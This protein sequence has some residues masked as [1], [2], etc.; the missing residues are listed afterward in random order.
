MAEY[1][2][3]ILRLNSGNPTTYDG[4][5]VAEYDPSR[6]GVSPDGIPMMAHLVGTDDP[7]K[8]M[9]FV[10]AQ[11]AGRAWRLESGY[12]RPDGKPDRPLTAFTCEVVELP[13]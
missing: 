10:S 2:L 13:E 11:A 4:Q 8:A 3:R 7:S 6:S 5:Y 1:G 9:R 12:I